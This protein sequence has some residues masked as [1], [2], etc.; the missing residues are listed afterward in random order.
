VS[1]SPV[2]YRANPIG[3]WRMVSQTGGVAA[4]LLA[5]F[6]LAAI[7]QLLSADHPPHSTPWA[8]TLFAAAAVALL[9]SLQLSSVALG[10]W[11]P[12][13]ER[14]ELYPEARHNVELMRRVQDRQWRESAVRA[15]YVDRAAI[16]YNSG[17][18]CFLSGL[19]VLLVPDEPWPWSAAHIVGLAV[20]IAAIIL[21]FIWAVSGSSRPRWLLPDLDP[22]PECDLD[23]VGA[24][25]LLF[26]D[27][28]APNVPVQPAGAA[29]PADPSMNG[30]AATGTGSEADAP[31]HPAPGN[32]RPDPPH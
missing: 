10:Y 24:Q 28:A 3:N 17:L 7:A 16:F 27:A 6:C 14:M 5:G 18:L 13:G 25:R 4:P 15:K 12:P 19:A 30:R 29:A 22:G 21:E 23:P 8:V 31:T 11:A 1:T 20:V 26:P 2:W 9:N 32:P